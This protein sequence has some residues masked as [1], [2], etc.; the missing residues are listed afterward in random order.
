MADKSVQ[1]FSVGTIEAVAKVVGELYSGSELTRIL[2]S[3][4][5]PDPLGEGMTKWKRLAASMQ[6]QQFNQRDGRPILALIIAAMAPDR[7]LDRRA[8]ASVTRDELTQILSLSGYA[9]R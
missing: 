6:E 7:T 5:L 3:V 8:A 9:V 1:A 4:N 2:A